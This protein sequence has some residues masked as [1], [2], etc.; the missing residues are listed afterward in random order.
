[1]NN[2]NKKSINRSFETRSLMK[3]KAQRH[4]SQLASIGD[5][6]MIKSWNRTSIAI[7]SCCFQFFI[8]ETFSTVKLNISF[9]ELIKSDLF[10]SEEVQ[11]KARRVEFMRLKMRKCYAFE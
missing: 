2:R 10:R 1:M 4:H 7:S 3:N 11:F 9:I 6:F 8:P 5:E